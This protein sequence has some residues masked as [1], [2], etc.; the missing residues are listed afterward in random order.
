MSAEPCDPP[1]GVCFAALMPH[2]PIL[3]PDVGRDALEPVAACASALK[4]V[5]AR[6]SAKHVDGV[7]V[8]SPHSPRRAGAFGVW[9]GSRL[10]GDFSQFGA[11]E[12]FVDL[13]ND[14]QL[15][16]ELVVQA[17]Q[18]GLQLWEIPSQPLDHGALVPLWY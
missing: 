4:T 18:L 13:P 1:G 15:T 11:V 17:R 16:G 2:A 9:S 10:R 6:L 14:L 5:A 8:V 3:V 12:A 7:V